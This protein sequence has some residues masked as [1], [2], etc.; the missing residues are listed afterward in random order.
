MPLGLASVFACG[1]FFPENALDKPQGI[2]QPPMFHY[3][4]EFYKLEHP[5]L[6]EALAGRKA[7]SPAI[8][9][10]LEMAEM[11]KI[12]AERLPAEAERQ[13]WL[14]DYRDLRRAMI[15]FGDVSAYALHHEDR[16]AAKPLVGVQAEAARILKPLPQDIRLYLEGAM[17]HLQG[18]LASE[19]N[20]E[21]DRLK[22]REKWKQV[23]A[24]PVTERNWRS[25]WAAWMLFRTCSPEEKAERGRW[26]A[27]TRQASDEGLADCLHL[28]I[29]ATYILGRPA[30]DLP[31]RKDVSAAQWKRAAYLRTL[32]GHSRA[33]EQLNRFDRWQGVPWSEELASQTLADPLLRQGQMLHLI[34]QVQGALG[35]DFGHHQKGDQLTDPELKNWLTSFE[36][37][38]LRDQ[39]EAL[40]LA[41]LHYNA[42]RF[43]EARRW[44]KIAPQED[45]VSLSLKGKLAALEGKKAETV[46]AL[47]A[48]AAQMPDLQDEAR[49]D[50]ETGA[51]F[52]V[53]P[54]PSEK[55][56]LIRRHHFLADYGRAQ[57]AVNDFTGALQ[58]FSKTD[59]WDDTAYIAEKLIS[60]D[61]LLTLQRAGKIRER[62]APH[63]VVGSEPKLPAKWLS[64]LNEKYGNWFPATGEP[65]VKYLVARRLA[66]EQ[67]FKN[68]QQMLPPDL[69]AGL[70]LY[71][72]ALRRG[73]DRKLP[74]VQRAELLWQAA[75]IHRLLGLEFFGY[76]TGPDYYAVGGSYVMRDLTKFRNQKVWMD[77]W[78]HDDRILESEKQVPVFPA[79]ADETWRARHYGPKV[80]K[81]FHYRYTAADL[82]WEAASLMP[83]DDPKTAEVLCITGNWLMMRDPKAADRFYKALVRRNPNVPL[84]Q[85]ADKKRW[86]PS[87]TWDFDL[88]LPDS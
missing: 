85:Q 17:H 74:K 64:Q 19:E 82:A 14:E 48:V 32:L 21:A 69:A 51:D 60:V 52:T 86:F 66:R 7:G 44:L 36:K 56:E 58:T 5:W 40:L 87:V 75:Q 45:I 20:Q 88:E 78:I 57:L 73:H 84:A 38:G 26:L 43:D 59:F 23:L 15:G 81:R 30:S 76:E 53:L 72:E 55:F 24:L 11:E 83:D 68:A 46:K 65:I 16:Q 35:W 77:D 33:E 67:Y 29:E 80:D 1:P 42:A 50:T 70:R 4:G 12:M 25:T 54:L 71:V 27:E 2:L 41:W 61:E 31:E 13:T 37:S 3:L 47:K 49:A 22:A 18:K 8:T 9:L 28:G 34:E 63:V 62:I 79:T 10:D 6:G 39:K